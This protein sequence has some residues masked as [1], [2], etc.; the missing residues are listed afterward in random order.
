MCRRCLFIAVVRCLLLC[1]VV[2]CCLFCVF[3]DS[4]FYLST[5]P[6]VVYPLRQCGVIASCCSFVLSVVW[7]WCC[8]CLTSLVAVVVCRG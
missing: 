5:L 8:C 4:C 7:C 3:A 2:A 1:V 6:C